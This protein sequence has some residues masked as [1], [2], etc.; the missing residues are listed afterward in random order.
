MCFNPHDANEVIEFLELKRPT[1][2]LTTLGN[3]VAST[4]HKLILPEG[5]PEG[6]IS[7][8]KCSKVKA[9]ESLLNH[10]QDKRCIA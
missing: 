10:S 3:L 9:G 1:Q 2:G 5:S 4:R 8:E 7:K 6:G